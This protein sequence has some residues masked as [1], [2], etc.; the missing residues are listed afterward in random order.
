VT[1]AEAL[2]R[3]AAELSENDVPDA[4]LDAFQLVAFVTHRDRTSLIAHPEVALSDEQESELASLTARRA[5][6]EPLQYILGRQE[7]H[8][9]T[10]DISPDVLIPR[11][12][13][14][15][16]VER[17]I[18]FLSS[19]SSPRFCEIGV[20]SGC[21]SISVL[22]EIKTASAAACD[23]SERALDVARR[24]AELHN[25]ADRLDLII[26]DVFGSMPDERF[27]AVLSN[28]P[29]VPEVD[30]FSLQPEVRDHEPTIALTSGAD[31]LKVIERLIA[32]APSF[33]R[34][35]GLLLFEMGFNQ[36]GSV[37]NL[38]DH[39]VWTG[40]EFLPDL[41]G[42]PRILAAVKRR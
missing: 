27:D 1:I 28:P 24:N 41:Q 15:I 39:T 33:L 12:E 21:I 3:C 19:R 16:L 9:L 14:E 4:R 6:R 34:T 11:P 18:K 32:E 30:F 29:Y 10:F 2:A 5:A 7:F 20:G 17:A 13:T 35:G 37:A 42:I 26:S 23:I 36:S 8:R 38:I 40:V 25:V 22:R 31:G